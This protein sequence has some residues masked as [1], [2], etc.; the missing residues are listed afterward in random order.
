MKIKIIINVPD[1]E[2]CGMCQLQRS[3]ECIIFGETSSFI[4]TGRE[5]RTYK[6][7]QCRAAEEL[8]K[9]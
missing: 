6:H 3:G 9:L 5:I 4:D 2:F 1:G 8:V 7:P